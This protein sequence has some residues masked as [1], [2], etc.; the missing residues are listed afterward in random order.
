VP[1]KEDYCSVSW[2]G[3]PFIKQA[4]KI[5]DLAMP[6]INGFEIIRRL[7]AEGWY[8][9]AI[10]VTGYSRQQD[11]QETLA[12]GFD[13]HLAKPISITVLVERI[14]ALR[15]RVEWG[16]NWEEVRKLMPNPPEISHG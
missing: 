2:K 14:V 6:D 3:K 4:A 8:G 11:V 9:P 16:G 7:R 13:E 1:I 12:S 5:S 10:A 15:D